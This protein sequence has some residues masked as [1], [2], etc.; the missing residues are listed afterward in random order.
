M[1]RFV[2]STRKVV[3]IEVI[4]RASVAL[5]PRDE[6]SNFMCGVTIFQP[7]ASAF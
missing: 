6:K 3:Y 4:C 1:H 7:E 2:C 5:H